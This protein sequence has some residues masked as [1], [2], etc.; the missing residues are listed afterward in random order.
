MDGFEVDDLE[1]WRVATGFDEAAE[2]RVVEEAVVDGLFHFWA[3]L[4]QMA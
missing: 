2:W 4:F 3:F 1:T